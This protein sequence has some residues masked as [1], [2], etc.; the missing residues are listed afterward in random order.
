MIESSKPQGI[1]TLAPVKHI[2]LP[3]K[4]SHGLNEVEDTCAGILTSASDTSC[5][6][7]KETTMEQRDAP[8]DSSEQGSEQSIALHEEQDKD[9]SSGRRVTFSTLEIREYPICV[10]DN[11]A[12][13]IGVPITIQWT[14]DGESIFS[15]EDYEEQRPTPRTMLQ[16]RMPS[17]CRADLLKRLGFS[18]TDV[19]EGTKHANIARNRRK[20][21]RETLKFQPAH[22]FLERARRATLNATL[23]RAAKRKE[24]EFLHRYAPIRKRECESLATVPLNNSFRTQ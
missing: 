24:K 14:H 21:T 2:V 15:V 20:R 1:L 18:R 23:K 22:E 8:M 11:P 17:R 6:D 3:M 7:G 13:S 4:D 5:D 19:M 16:L 12:V 9:E 10:G